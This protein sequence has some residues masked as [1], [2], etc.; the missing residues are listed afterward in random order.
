MN[1]MVFVL[2]G[3]DFGNL[4]DSKSPENLN[5]EEHRRRSRRHRHQTSHRQSVE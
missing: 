4:F 2:C 1:L 5:K 3:I